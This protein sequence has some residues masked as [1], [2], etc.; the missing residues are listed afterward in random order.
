MI[1]HAMGRSQR[2]IDLVT[3]GLWALSIGRWSLVTLVAQPLTEE[4]LTHA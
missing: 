2:K 3:I 4:G 1:P